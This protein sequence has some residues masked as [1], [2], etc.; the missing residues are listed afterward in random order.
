MKKY[1]LEKVFSLLDNAPVISYNEFHG[2]KSQIIKFGKDFMYKNSDRYKLFRKNNKC[3]CC[4][5][6]GTYFKK[7][8]NLKATHTTC[9]LNMFGVKNG[10]EVMFTKDH[11]IPK[12]KGG[13]DCFENYQT[14]CQDCNTLKGDK[15][16]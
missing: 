7:K 10:K 2:D 9:H 11:I 5:L 13:T 3:V 16:C 4:G 15:L 6:E 14:M 1:P 12:S 8:F